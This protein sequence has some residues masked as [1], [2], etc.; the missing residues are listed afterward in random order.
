MIGFCL[1]RVFRDAQIDAN[2]A[3]KSPTCQGQWITS[4]G[5]PTS[6]RTPFWRLLEFQDFVVEK[7]VENK[8]KFSPLKTNLGGGFK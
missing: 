1:W 8:Q 7:K 3:K 6:P 2:P 5:L 4:L